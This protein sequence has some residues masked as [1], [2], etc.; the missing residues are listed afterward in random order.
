MAE[1]PGKLREMTK[2]DGDHVWNGFG[3][4]YQALI[5]RTYRHGRITRDKKDD[6]ICGLEDDDKLSLEFIFDR[7][8]RMER[9]P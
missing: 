6:D 9:F 1:S 7:S 8:I 4:G 5:Q 3:N 2:P